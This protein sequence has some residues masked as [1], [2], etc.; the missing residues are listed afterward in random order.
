MCRRT[1]QTVF[2]ELGENGRL[3]I[4]EQAREAREMA[5][6]DNETFQHRQEGAVQQRLRSV[7]AMA[8]P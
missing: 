3:R 1:A 5:E 2:H 6:I 8:G 4:F 7:A